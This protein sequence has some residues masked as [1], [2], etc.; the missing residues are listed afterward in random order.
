MNV[1]GSIWVILWI[2]LAL[3][4]VGLALYRKMLASHDDDVVHVR[5]GVSRVVQKLDKIDFWGKTLTLVLIVYGLMLA[6]W[7][8]YQLWEQK[9]EG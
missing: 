7:L 4:V 2:C 9:R 3:S 6:A 8:L 1:F 5:P